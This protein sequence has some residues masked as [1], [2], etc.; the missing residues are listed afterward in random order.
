MKIIKLI[1]AGEEIARVTDG[2]IDKIRMSDSPYSFNLEQLYDACF[3]G[4]KNAIDF[5]E[6]FELAKNG[7]YFCWMKPQLKLETEEI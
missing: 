5:D 4:I 3:Y 7:N 1:L 2:K 6:R